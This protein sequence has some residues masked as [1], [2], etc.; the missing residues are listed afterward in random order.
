[1]SSIERK[2]EVLAGPLDEELLR[3]RAATG[4][5]P[6]GVVWERT[7]DEP[8]QDQDARAVPY[9]LR[10]GTDCQTL[11]PAGDEIRAMI[12]MLRMVV[13]EH[14]FAQVASSLNEAGFR[15]R[16]G[17][18]WN[19]TMVFHMM[20]RLIE[21]APNIYSSESWQ[22]LRPRVAAETD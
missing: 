4:W 17:E 13:E 9:G 12:H 2:H 10:V 20:P 11:E 7:T 6:V 22:A 14:S 3:Q 1:M 16:A 15:T 8:V 18:E 19:Q 5:R 21:N